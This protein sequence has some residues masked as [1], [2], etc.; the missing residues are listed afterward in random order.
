MANKQ[1]FIWS[2][3]S[4]VIGTLRLDPSWR[5]LRARIL[6]TMSRID[7]V[8]IRYWNTLLYDMI[9]IRYRFLAYRSRAWP[10]SVGSLSSSRFCFSL[11]IL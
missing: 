6:Y 2:S 9:S 3:A 7:T 4:P 5:H 8:S 1:P 11:Q 10:S